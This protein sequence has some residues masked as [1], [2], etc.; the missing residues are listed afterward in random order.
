M[1][2][3]STVQ[4]WYLATYRPTEEPLLRQ[5]DIFNEITTVVLVDSLV[6]FSAANLESFDLEADIGFL[7]LL[8][9]NILVHLFFLV[10][11]SVNSVKDSI[12]KRK[13]QGKRVCC[14]KARPAEKL[15]ASMNEI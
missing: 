10:K 1:M 4:V 12:K 9:G 15:P 13:A 7:A 11:S 14:F 5:L 3:S 8:F 2:I 6:I